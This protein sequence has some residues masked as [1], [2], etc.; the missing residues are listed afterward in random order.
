[1]LMRERRVPVC[2][3]GF[4]VLAVDGVPTLEQPYSERR[5]ILDALDFAGPC[6]ATVPSFADAEAPASLTP[7]RCGQS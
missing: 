1:M 5:A 7:R 4:E 6:W 3:L 2:F